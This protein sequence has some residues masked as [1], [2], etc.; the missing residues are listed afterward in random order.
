[1]LS[2]EPGCCDRYNKFRSPCE[3]DERCDSY[4]TYFVRRLG[5]TDRGEN[6]TQGS[7]LSEQQGISLPNVDDASIDFS[8][9]T[10]LGLANPLVLRG[11]DNRWNVSVQL[12]NMLYCRTIL[13]SSLQ[14]S[15]FS[16]CF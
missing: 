13:W 11:L 14:K 5:S 8:N 7:S 4:F 3:S 12:N 9:A 1:M 6:C 15:L 10:V 2:T 16:Q